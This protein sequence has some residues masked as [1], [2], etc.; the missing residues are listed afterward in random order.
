MGRDL[1]IPCDMRKGFSLVVIGL[2]GCTPSAPEESPVSPSQAE[3]DA[4]PEAEPPVDPT[5]EPEPAPEAS[6][7]NVQMTAATLADDCGGGPNTPARPRAKAKPKPTAKGDQPAKSKAKRAKRRC[8]QSSIQLAV[9]APEGTPSAKL[10]VKSV[11]LLLTNGTS[12][13]M[14]DTRAP[15]VWA[16]GDG[17]SPW[18]ETVNPGDD[19]SVSY[20]VTQPDWSQ[21]N[22][23]RSQTYTMKAVVSIA[24]TDQTLEQSVV[25]DIPTA[26]PPGVKT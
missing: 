5:P 26:L 25:L 16:D 2:L 15:S 9:T 20:A 21:V 11:E 14:L 3:P 10:A 7:V 17:Y 13:G 24:G 8:K 23:R 4:K 1:L 12:L 6:G 19:L 22:D 18:D